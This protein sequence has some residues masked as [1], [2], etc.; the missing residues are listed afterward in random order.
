MKRYYKPGSWNAVCQVCGF[1]HKSDELKRRW[2]GLMV[3]EDDFEL[4]NPQDLIRPPKDDSSIPW[5]SPEQYTFL[6]SNITTQS[7]DALITEDGNNLI[8]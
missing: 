7:G 1:T 2:D 8:W 5:A 3:C 4:R 6:T